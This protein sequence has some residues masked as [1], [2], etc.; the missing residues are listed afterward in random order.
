M[1]GLIEEAFVRRNDD[2]CQQCHEPFAEW[3]RG[4]RLKDPQGKVVQGYQ[5]V[6][7]DCCRAYLNKL[8]YDQ[9]RSSIQ[10]GEG[11]GL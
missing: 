7:E 4:Y 10:T 9:P 2:P 6:C 8:L 5:R 11:S 3:E 1:S